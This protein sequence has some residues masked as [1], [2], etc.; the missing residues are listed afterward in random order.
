ML[1]HMCHMCP[2]PRNVPKQ[3][4][5]GVQS[6]FVHNPDDERRKVSV[7]P[8]QVLAQV[9]AQQNGGKA[10]EK[11]VECALFPVPVVG[12]IHMHS[13][14]RHNVYSVGFLF[15]TEI[16]EVCPFMVV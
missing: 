4:S 13:S 10:D 7:L 3:P 1:C 11:D 12:V 14:H 2:S 15:L 8:M 9:Y 5:A 16:S 6:T